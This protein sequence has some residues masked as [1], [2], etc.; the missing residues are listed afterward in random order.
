[1]DTEHRFVYSPDSHF[2]NIHFRA[3][4]HDYCGIHD[5]KGKRI[6]KDEKKYKFILSSRLTVLI[7]MNKLVLYHLCFLHNKIISIIEV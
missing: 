2:P 5:D 6:N 4:S 1:M 3:F 7:I